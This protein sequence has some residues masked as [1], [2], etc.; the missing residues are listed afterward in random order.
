[1]MMSIGTRHAR[2][3]RKRSVR[4][5]KGGAYWSPILVAMKPEPQTLTKYQ[6]SAASN[7]EGRD[8]VVV[9]EGARLPADQ[10]APLLLGA[11][12]RSVGGLDHF[13]GSA[14]AVV[15][16]GDADAHRH[17]YR[18]SPAPAAA[19]ALRAAALAR[20]VTR[21][22]CHP[23]VLD[24]PAQRLQVGNRIVHPSAG[25]E[26]GELL[27]PVA[28]SEPAA[29]DLGD[30]RRHQLEDLVSDF[31]AVGVVEA[32]E[33]VHVQH[34]DDVVAAEDRKSTRLNSS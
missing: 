24:F 31:M 5:V 19:L 17:R 12:E 26:N 10:V 3:N 27:A 16:L 15:T 29:A 30:M 1:M 2:P 32:F 4:N 21:A 13:L 6:A 7:Q 8:G 25:K 18:V 22:H 23:V 11:V 14:E 9:M 28:I 34:G 33:M 20:A